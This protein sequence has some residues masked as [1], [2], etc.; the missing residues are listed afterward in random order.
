MCTGHS[1]FA[2]ERD[3]M[4]SVVFALSKVRFTD[5]KATLITQNLHFTCTAPKSPLYTYIILRWL[6]HYA[7]SRKVAGSNPDEITGFF[8][9]PNPSSRTMVLGSTQLLTEMST[10]NLPGG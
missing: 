6:R 8:N 3:Y 7:T 4:G 9:L 2:R 10:T 1:V 5:E